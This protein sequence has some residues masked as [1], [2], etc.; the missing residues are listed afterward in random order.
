[1]ALRILVPVLMLSTAA[2]PGAARA[3]VGHLGDVAGHSHWVG[4]AALAGAAAVAGVMAL[5]GRRKRARDEGS[6]SEADAEAG[7]DAA[8]G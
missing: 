3:H 2:L 8:R 1:M 6:Q 4:V 5:K 7:A